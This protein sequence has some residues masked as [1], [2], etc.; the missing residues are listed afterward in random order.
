[1][2][3]ALS[4][5]APALAAE[6]WPRLCPE[7][8]WTFVPGGSVM[9]IAAP[10]PDKVCFL[11]MA[12]ALSRI[13]RFDGRG[14]PVAQHLV[15]GAEAI[16][17]EVRDEHLAALYLLH[18]GHE[19]LLG[20]QT[21]P[22]MQLFDGVINQIM[23][24]ALPQRRFVFATDARKIIASGWDRAIYCAAGKPDPS[25]WT[26]QQKAR[27][28]GMDERMLLAEAVA[29]FGLAAADELPR[30]KPPILR[31]A[32]HPWGPEKAEEKFTD[33]AKE[34]L[35]EETVARQSRRVLSTRPGR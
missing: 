30:M 8:A 16:L 34:L 2:N 13:V 26:E 32:V 22:T 20:D 17:R 5:P 23:P 33:M 10:H 18:D 15:M 27:V 21:R 1:M 7:P 9:D 6:A 25:A 29:T 31:G 19:W 11:E 4:D 14:I 28:K 24:P 12:T 35:G 3:E